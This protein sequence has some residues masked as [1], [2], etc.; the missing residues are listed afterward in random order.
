MPRKNCRHIREV[1][2]RPSVQ[3]LLGTQSTPTYAPAFT[4]TYL[5]NGGILPELVY[6]NVQVTDF[7]YGG[8][9]ITHVE[10]PLPSDDHMLWTIA[11]DLELAACL[12]LATIIEVLGLPA[13]T[14]ANTIR[15]RIVTCGRKFYQAPRNIDA[16]STRIEA[17]GG[18]PAPEDWAQCY[19]TH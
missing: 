3:A 8:G 2:G 17:C 12:P 18:N 5:P 4:P 14:S 19:G 7:T 11:Y 9:A 15:D 6:S 16:N 10:I 13:G 1:L